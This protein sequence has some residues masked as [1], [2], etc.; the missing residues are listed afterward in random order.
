MVLPKIPK[1]I[2]VRAIKDISAYDMQ[3]NFKYE[4]KKNNIYT[5]YL[6]E[7]TE[8]YFCNNENGGE[9]IYVGCINCHNC[10]ELEEEFNLQFGIP[11]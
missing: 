1:N 9:P 11:K 10:L 5:A 8:E 4:I 6:Y 7:D 3:G 2:A